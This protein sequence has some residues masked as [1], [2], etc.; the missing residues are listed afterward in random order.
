MCKDNN[1]ERIAMSTN[2]SSTL[3]TYMSLINA[4]VNDLSISLDS[5]CCAIGDMMAGGIKGSWIKVTNNIKELSKLTYVSVGMVF[6]EDNVEGCIDSIL[7]ADS[8]GVSDIR[9]IPSAQYNKALSKLISLPQEII[10]KYPILKYRIN[11][12]KN[13]MHVRGMTETDSN[14]C[15]IVLD[16]LA[17]AGN[18]HFP[19]IIYLRE[20]G[21]P[22][23]AMNKDFRK[24]RLEWHNN[25]NVLKDPIC[26]ANCLDCLVKFNNIALNGREEC[27]ERI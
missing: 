10:N 12:I 11:N 13:N 16:D 22:I 26:R 25:H 27:R 21:K 2:G 3:E 17:C 23:G 9:V 8:L 19:C 18:Y 15:F 6:T 20:G 14:K 5:G 24:D 7:F 4:G 1:V